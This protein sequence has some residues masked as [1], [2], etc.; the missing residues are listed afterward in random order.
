MRVDKF[1]LRRLL[2]F[3]PLIVALLWAGSWVVRQAV[4]PATYSCDTTTVN[5]ESG[6]TL[7]SI[8][9]THC[10]GDTLAVIDLLVKMYGTN[11]DT[12][13]VIHLPIAS[14]RS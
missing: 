12:W 14:P 4:E 7:D 11:L 5:V 13:Q 8:T 10:V 3:S 9:R 2:V 6:D 1:T